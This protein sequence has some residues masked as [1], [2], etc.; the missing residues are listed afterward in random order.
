KKDVVGAITCFVKALELDPGYSLA[1]N[2]L[3]GTLKENGNVD[4]ASSEHVSAAIA[5]YRK[6]L[7]RHPS[8]Q[9]YYYLAK[10][11]DAR[12]DY[13]GAIDCLEAA[14]KCDDKFVPAHHDLGFILHIRKNNLD[15]AIACYHKAL[16]HD[17]KSAPILT[18]LGFALQ[19]KPDLKEAI[20]CYR[21]ALKYDPRFATAHFNLGV[22]LKDM[23]DLDGAIYHFKKTLGCGGTS[24]RARNNLVRALHTEVT[25]QAAKL[26]SDLNYAAD[27]Q[28]KLQGWQ[29]D[30]DLAGVRDNQALAQL[31]EG[32]RKDWQSLWAE[33]ADLLQTAQKL[34]SSQ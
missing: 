20:A 34:T 26:K 8:A 31:P 9:P 15:G 30:P 4:G 23:K 22:A 10:F 14:R 13:D 7:K 24:P 25:D 28:L 16:E 12:Q 5:S 2:N 29:T 21:E 17:P 32:E 27:V 19:S 3:M 33:V 1:H 6:H 18:N 11:L